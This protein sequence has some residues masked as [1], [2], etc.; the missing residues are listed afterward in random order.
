MHKDEEETHEPKRYQSNHGRAR[1]AGTGIRSVMH[2]LN[3]RGQKRHCLLIGRDHPCEF[4]LHF[5]QTDTCDLMS[6]QVLPMSTSL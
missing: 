4:I 3:K 2:P 1:E 6:R 5:F